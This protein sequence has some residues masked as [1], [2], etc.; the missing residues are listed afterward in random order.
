MNYRTLNFREGKKEMEAVPKKGEAM[1]T[2]ATFNEKYLCC[3]VNVLRSVH[4]CPFE[5]TYCFLQNYLNENMTKVVSDIGALMLEVRSKISAEPRRLFRI[6]TWE[7]GDSLALENETGQAAALVKEFSGLGNAVLEL[8]TK[9]DIV[10][11]ILGLEHKGKTVVSWSLNTEHVTGTE[12]H[13]TASLER[14]LEAIHKVVR[15]DYMIGLHFDPMIYHEGW[16]RGYASL[17]E[18]VFEAA[19]PERIAWISIGSL[20]FNPEM[21]K[22]IEINYPESRLTCAEMV[23]GDDAKVRYVKPLRVGM[24]RLLYGEMKKY[25]SEDNLVYLCMERWDVWD[26]VFG[27]YPGSI[28]RLDYLFAKSLYERFEIGERPEE[29]IYVRNSDAVQE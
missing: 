12:E 18:R 8:K 20:R 10:D 7:L 29:E 1:G 13:G 11:P 15:A 28:A 16:E 3:R 4:N 23:L 24:Y 6:G 21:K 17:V 9:S 27:H 14:R 5:C 22:K 2:C 25:I 19:P 26:R